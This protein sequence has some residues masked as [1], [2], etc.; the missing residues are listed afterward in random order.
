ML[1][2]AGVD[3]LKF[4]M[5]SALFLNNLTVFWQGKSSGPWL[6]TI[7]FDLSLSEKGWHP[8]LKQSLFR[9]TSPLRS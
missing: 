6:A 1:G 2:Q 3:P 9:L 8:I 7:L 5:C 4:N